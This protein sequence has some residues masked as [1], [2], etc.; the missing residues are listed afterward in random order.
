MLT[1]RDLTLEAMDGHPSIAGFH[2]QVPPGG[3]LLLTGASGRARN[4]LLKA[5]AGTE[6]PTAGSI[7][8][9]GVDVWPGKGA[10]AL[11]G[12]VSVGLAFA[13]GGLLANLT[14]R[15]NVALPLRF[16]GVPS[17]QM[18]SRVE[19]ALDVFDLLQVAGLR[20]HAVSDAARKH[21]NLARILA[22]EPALV[23][24][25]DPLIGLEA[26]DRSSALELI[27]TWAGDAR[28]TLIMAAEDGAA[29][30]TIETARQ[31]IPSVLSVQEP[32]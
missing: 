3:N 27:R 23:L 20:P 25:D 4:R 5:I 12:K 32:A 31:P 1:I 15:D 9:G 28:C 29:Y 11:V 2:A 18:A 17:V 6:R 13:R 14:L 8:V 26:D 7:R 21:A 10:F 22:L 19:A 24:L 16:L 30:A